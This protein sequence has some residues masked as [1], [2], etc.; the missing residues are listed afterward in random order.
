MIK[1]QITQLEDS[2]RIWRVFVF[3]FF[4]KKIKGQ[5]PH[6]KIFTITKY[7]IEQ[8]IRYFISTMMT[9]MKETHNNNMNENMKK[10]KPS[11][12]M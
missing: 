6:E 7:R 9:I 8:Q 10:L 1:Q 3:F 4:S 5:K 11:L 12:L 2:Q